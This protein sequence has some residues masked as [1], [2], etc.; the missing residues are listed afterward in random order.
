MASIEKRQTNQGIRYRARITLKGHPRLSE[1]FRTRR[2]AV[3]WA[4]RT[5]E[6]IRQRR[7]QPESEAEQRTMG[8]LVER[9]MEEKSPL[10]AR[11]KPQRRCLEWW[12]DQLGTDTRLCQITPAT[13]ASARDRLAAG[14][15]SGKDRLSPSSVK[16]YLTVLGGAF[17]TATKDWHWLEENPC[18]RVRRPSEPRGRV[19]FLDKDE[20]HRLLA[21]CEESRV[22]FLYPLVVMALCTGAR[23]GELLNLKWQDVDLDRG[24]AIVHHSKNGER[25]ALAITGPAA[26]VLREWGRVRRLG[27]VFLFPGR[28]GRATFPRDAWQAALKTAGIDDFRFHDLRHTFASYLAMSGATLAELAE[29]LGHKTLAMVKRYAHL[30]EGHI[31]TV[32]GRMTERFMDGRSPLPA[33]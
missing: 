26:E 4:E 32:V 10:L 28:R 14:G 16:R 22:E 15:L 19:R 33:A 8:D 5:T 9:Y 20:R 29:A 2:E 25:R 12:A 3:R 31:Q 30:T 18:T 1:T 21:A 27:S 11:A 23:R 17:A 6:A 24:I 7:F 13:I